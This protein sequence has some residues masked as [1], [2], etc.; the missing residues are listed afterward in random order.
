MKKNLPII[1]LFIVAILNIFLLT[2]ISVSKIEIKNSK[3]SLNLI[4]KNFKINKKGDI[5]VFK[6]E[7]TANIGDFL[8]AVE[9]KGFL[10][11]KE[12]N[13]ITIYY[14]NKL[15][16]KVLL[17]KN[18]PVKKIKKVK[19]IINKRT[20]LKYL[21]III[22]D[23]GP[24]F[25][26]AEKIWKINDNITLSIIPFLKDSKKISLFALEK[27]YHVMLHIPME[28]VKN[29]HKKDNF[30]LTE[31]NKKEFIRK[32]IEIFDFLPFYEGINNHM[33]SRLT[34]NREKMELFFNHFE[35]NKFFI[36]SKTAKCTIAG[37][38]ALSYN[39]LSG[40]RDIFI[41][42]KKE[43]S[44]ILN[45]L[46]KAEKLAEKEGFAIAIGHP[47]RRTIQAL[48]VFIA[49]KNKNLVILPVIVGLKKFEV[50]EKKHILEKEIYE[51]SSY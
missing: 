30:L 31:M 10:V 32:Q 24:N 12:K 22:D 37:K 29:L 41:D 8:K 26:K 45:N 50:Y 13:S 25:Q 38:I 48:S 39:I 27:G 6:Y 18:L 33:G 11:E 4:F 21:S 40:I 28:P 7:D 15:L 46:K 51:G 47:D 43:F 17:K 9:K 44:K 1:I 49:N 5:A 35:K 14:K 36:D 3:K 2:F 16:Y 19:E 34:C 23:L 42:N 20:N